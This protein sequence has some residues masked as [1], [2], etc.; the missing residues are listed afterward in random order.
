MVLYH[1]TTGQGIFGILNSSKLHCSNI[2]FLN[3]PSEE[4]Y[5]KEVLSE[6][7]AASNECRAIHDKLYNQSYEE[8]IL[9]P[10]AKFIVSFSKNPDSLSMWNYY[11]SGNGYSIGIDIDSVITANKCFE[12]D[13]LKA[14]VLF[15]LMD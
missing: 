4:T 2:N 8:V 10:T 3:D 13:I 7:L 6:V 11:A 5:F 1:Y 9:N 14:V 12:M 15:I